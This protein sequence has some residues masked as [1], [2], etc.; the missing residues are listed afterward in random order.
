MN[1]PPGNANRR[2]LHSLVRD[3]IGSCT[4]DITVILRVE[5]NIKEKKKH[6]REGENRLSD[7]QITQEIGIH[8]G[9]SSSS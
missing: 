5:V 3:C 7:Q 8:A 1:S 4:A 9:S 2:M 6:T